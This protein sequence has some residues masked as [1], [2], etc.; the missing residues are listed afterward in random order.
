M[1]CRYAEKNDAKEAAYLIHLA[2]HDIAESLTGE[3]EQTKIREVLAQLFSQEDNRLS[4]QNCL[5]ME[6]DNNLA[7]IIIAYAG[8]DAEALDKPILER[9]YRK[10]DESSIS[11][12]KEADH[13]DYYLD[14]VSVK[15]EYQGKRIGTLLIQEA[16][17]LASRKGYNR[18]SLNVAEDNPRAKQLYIKLGYNKVK[19]I[20]ING[21][22]YDYMVKQSTPVKES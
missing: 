18:V 3:S 15:P 6:V 21:H 14:T 22:E 11:L 13:G 7:G 17:K 19:V 20:E 9:L 5:V 12:D 1:K 16:E 10:S 4:Y 2:I 8:D